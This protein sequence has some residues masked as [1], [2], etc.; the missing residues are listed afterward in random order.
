MIRLTLFILVVLL[1]LNDKIKEGNDTYSCCGGLV[2]GDDFESS[3]TDA[4]SRISR[5]LKNE[6]WNKPCT[7]IGSENCCEGNDMCMPSIFGGKC[8]YKSGG[9]YYIYKEGRKVG[10]TQNQL[11]TEKDQ[12]DFQKKIDDLKKDS[13]DSKTALW[14]GVGL[15]ATLL[16]IMGSI[17][18]YYITV[19]NISISRIIR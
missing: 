12:D 8:R 5:C 2:P 1:L 7:N 14:I 9:G 16:V 6:I 15:M 19:N 13:E 3:D 17:G 18:A 4:P 10:L 11:D